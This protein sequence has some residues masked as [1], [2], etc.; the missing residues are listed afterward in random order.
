[1]T[2]RK[3]SSAFAAL[4]FAV[5]LATPVLAQSVVDA[6][7]GGLLVEGTALDDDILI[8]PWKEGRKIAGIEII[9]NDVSLG[10][11]SLAERPSLTVRG[12]EGND[13]IRLNRLPNAAFNLAAYPEFSLTITGDAGD[14]VIRGSRLHDVIYGNAGD[15]R[16]HGG[17]GNDIILGGDGNDRLH[18][19]RGHDVVEGNAGDF[20]RLFGD[21]GHDKI[22]DKDGARVVK[23]GDGEDK[24][25]LFWREGWGSEKRRAPKPLV[26]GG[27]DADHIELHNLSAADMTLR[28]DGDELHGYDDDGDRALLFGWFAEDMP[29]PKVETVTRF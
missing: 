25:V 4:A 11:W 12:R 28:V 14:D 17:P 24:L 5:L 8:Q 6:P 19:N 10:A 9:I 23:G 21:C 13:R 2:I 7:D 26:E 27:Y 20:D 22:A 15:D 1:M 3:C 16:I 29:L 18:G